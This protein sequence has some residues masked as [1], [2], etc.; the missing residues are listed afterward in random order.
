[1]K[2]IILSFAIIAL[3]AFSFNAAADDNNTSN[4]TGCKAR[5][6][7]CGKC[8]GGAKKAGKGKHHGKKDCKKG[9][10]KHGSMFEG[11]TLS[12]EQQAKIDSLRNARKADRNRAPKGKGNGQNLDEMK[13]LRDEA[14]AKSRKEFTMQIQQILTPEQF[15]VFEQ[16]LKKHES[17]KDSRALRK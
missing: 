3:G 11:I 1:M 17:K 5:T 15:S 7:C 8:D 10:R 6:E 9:D 12:A 2:K 13:K 4:A 16:N 14:R